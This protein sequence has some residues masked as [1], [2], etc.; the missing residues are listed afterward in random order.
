MPNLLRF[1]GS[2]SYYFMTDMPFSHAISRSCRHTELYWTDMGK[3]IVICCDGTGNEVGTNAYSNVVRFYRCLDRTDPDRQVVFYDPGLGTL[4]PPGYHSWTFSSIGRTLGLAFGVGFRQNIKEAYLFLMRVYQPGDRIYLIGFSRG[5]YTVRALA[6]LISCCGLLN[7]GDEN[8]IDYAIKRHHQRIFNRRCIRKHVSSLRRGDCTRRQCVARA[9]RELW[10]KGWRI[11]NWEAMGRFKK[12]FGR[13]CPI[14]FIGVWDTV[15]SIGLLR[16]STIIPRTANLRGVTSGRHAVS[17]DERRTKYRPNLWKQRDREAFKQVWFPGVHSDIGGGYDDSSLSDIAL[18]W[19]LTEAAQ[20]ELL[21]SMDGYKRTPDHMGKMHR[22][23]LP[24]WWLL[25]WKRRR[26]LPP[27]R[28]S[29][30]AE[31]TPVL[32][33]QSALDRAASDPAYQAMLAKSLC[34]RP[35]TAICTVRHE[36]ETDHA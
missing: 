29:G 27:G 18:E 3:N 31:L 9:W 20:Y 19:M 6:A 16:G 34:G 5:A 17:L 14:H 1:R 24:I 2:P 10:Q 28:Y 12:N 11:P 22:S 25:G 7:Y 33:H 15:K 35:H 32:V 21:V 8:L 26:A 4:A 13:T 23:L 36:P 30:Q